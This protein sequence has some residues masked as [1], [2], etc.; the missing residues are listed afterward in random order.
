MKK[1]TISIRFVAE[2]LAEARRRGLDVPALTARAGF[3][4]ELLAMPLARVSPQQYGALWH[5]LAAA[6]DDEFFGMDSHPMRP[7]SFALLCHAVLDAK[8]LG[9]ALAR[10]LRFFALV[11]DDV[12]GRLDIADGRAT[13]DLADRGPPARLFAHGTLFVIIH[14]LACWLVGRRLPI[15][16]ATFCQRAPDHVAEYRLLFGESVR[17]EQPASS[18]VLDAAHLALAP[19]RDAKAAREFLLDAPANFL[20]KYRHQNGPTARVRAHLCRLPPA[21]WPD[22]EA[23]AAALHTTASTLRRHLE[24]E[25]HSYQAIKDDL[26]RD[27]AVDQLCNSA[28]SIADIAHALGFAEHSAFHRAFRKWTGASPGEYRHGAAKP[29]GRY[30]G[31]AMA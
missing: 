20:L 16:A 7:G 4:A 26:R 24:H 22:F 6:L 14:G 21:D 30:A 8:D 29:L 11:L 23:L 3:S 5:A 25:G 19:V 9:H 15:L 13:L 31:R 28:S 12:T 17:F 10:M 18:L 1:G 27:L 2:A